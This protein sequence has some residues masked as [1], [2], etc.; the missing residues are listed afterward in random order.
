MYRSPPLRIAAVLVAVLG[1][2]SF[3]A[4]RGEVFLLASGGRIEGD[5]LNRDESPRKTYVVQTPLGGQLTLA[6]SQVERVVVQKDADKQYE[7][8]VRKMPNTLEGHLAM[9]EW[10]RANDL[11][12]KRQYHLEQ[13]IERDPN[14]EAARHGLGYNKIEGQWLKTDEYMKSQGYVRHQGAWRLRQEAASDAAERKFELDVVAWK[15]KLKL[16]RTRYDKR[17]D[18]GALVEMRGANEPAAS[19]AFADLLA[20]EDYRELKMLY[21]EMLGQIPTPAGVAALIRHSLQDPDESIRDVCLRELAKH[22]RQQAASVY[23]KALTGKDNALINRAGHGLGRLG[24][25]DAILPLI[26]AL[27]TQHKTVVTSGGS[28]SPTFGGG[29]SGLSAGSKTTVIVNNVSNESVLGA[30]RAITREDFQF[31]EGAW[32]EWYIESRT[33]KQVNLRR[34]DD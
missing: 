28:I 9:A 4:A 33:P 31:D 32:R 20:N 6:K 15:K 34:R 1:W 30:L 25:E 16:L 8:A 19:V 12:A 26:D 7:E 18:G 27:V 10:C 29:G 13:V 21:V 11:R 17:G 24:Q 2:Q 14:H 3:S 5:W 22:G 23:L